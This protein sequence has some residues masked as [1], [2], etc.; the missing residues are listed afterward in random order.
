[1]VA[2]GS[3]SWAGFVI[4]AAVSAAACASDGTGGD[5]KVNRGTGSTMG[6][7]TE[8]AGTVAPPSFANAPDAGV[9]MAMTTRDASSVSDPGA[10]ECAGQMQNARPIPVDMYMMVDR[11]DSMRLETGTGAT[12]WD[13]LRSALTTFIEDPQ[14]DG[15]GVG[16][17]YFPLGAPGIP[18]SCGSDTECGDNGGTCANRVCRPPPTTTS[19]TPVFCGTDADCPIFQPC[20]PM[21]VCEMDQTMAC[22][23]LGKGGCD[24][25]GACNP[26]VGE[27]TRYAT[28]MVGDYSTPA[29]PIA[30]LPKNAA[31]LTA[32]LMSEQPIGLTPTQAAL[33]G[34]LDRAARQATDNPTHR[35]IAVLATDGLPTDCVGPNVTTV[36]LAVDEVAMTAST[37]FVG[38]PSIETYVIGVFAPDD[39]D[40]M[41]KLDQIAAAGGTKKAFI[42]DSSQD[43]SQQLLDALAKIRGG[44]LDCALELPDPPAGEKLDPHYVNVQF[45]SDGKVHELS[46][47]KTA[48]DCG[49]AELGW[50]YDVDPD[51]PAGGTP[52]QIKVCQ[53]TCDD[54]HNLS[55][56]ASIEIKLGCKSRAPD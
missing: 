47:V 4:V 5:R 51:G 3:R 24:T 53:Q 6:S 21:G 56:G 22:F 9:V 55:A 16:L 27:C 44:T 28:C 2:V 15:L 13:A 18:D 25:L 8:D 31:P 42:I 46:Y 26:L 37:G 54:F 34:A 35:V 36:D 19:F 49:K 30:A 12:K 43:V 50:Y 23:N 14:S 45:T 32:S 39:P 7:S 17:Q 20:V 33:S 29:V 41:T 48:A 40:P 10:S 1:M 11:S 52:S 38:H